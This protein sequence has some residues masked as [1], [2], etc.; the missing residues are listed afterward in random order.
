MHSRRLVC[1][2]LFELGIAHQLCVLLQRLRHLL[3]LPWGEHGAAIC[4]VG[5]GHGERRQHD[6]AGEC[7]P[8]RQP[9][10]A[11]RGVDAGGFT[12]PFLRNRGQCV[13]VEL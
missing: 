5:E 7:Q 2:N 10:G 3:L 4:H 1:E 9:E 6:G 8:E 12:D 13:V 11:G